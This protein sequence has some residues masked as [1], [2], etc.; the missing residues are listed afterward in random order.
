MLALNGTMLLSVQSPGTPLVVL[1]LFT[2]VVAEVLYWK[3]RP[4]LARPLQLRVFAFVVPSSLYAG[5]F[6]LERGRSGIWW[7]VH[8]WSGAIFL[9]GAVGV[10]V[11]LLVLPNA[12]PSVRDPFA[13]EAVVEGSGAEHVEDPLGGATVA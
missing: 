13:E 6:A 3:L 10:L 7:P 5:Y 4:A 12:A 9:A 1:P 11:S 2:G 8:V